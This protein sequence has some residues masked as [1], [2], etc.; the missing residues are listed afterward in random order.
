[1]WSVRE[2]A[3][4]LE[5]RL[6][7]A[8]G[9][10]AVEATRRQ[11]VVVIEDDVRTVEDT[12]ETNDETSVTVI[13]HTSPVVTLTCQVG[14]GDERGLVVCVNEHLQYTVGI[15]VSVNEHTVYGEGS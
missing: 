9:W 11:L 14:E 6:I 1:M 7:A 12:K 10:H 8:G 13:C 15:I 2:T 4:V 5:E 3:D